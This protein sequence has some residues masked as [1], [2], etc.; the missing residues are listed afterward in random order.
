MTGFSQNNNSMIDKIDVFLVYLSNEGREVYLYD[1]VS[2][3]DVMDALHYEPLEFWKAYGG[4]EIVVNDYY[5]ILHVTDFSYL[6]K[7]TSF[8]IHSLY[9]LS[10]KKAEWFDEDKSGC[11]ILK[12]TSGN[13]V[14]LKK[15]DSDTIC[16]SYLPAEN[17]YVKKRGDK[18][19]EG[20]LFDVVG[21]KEAVNM[22]L[23][24]YFKILNELVLNN[25]EDPMS[26]T[27]K[28]YLKLWEDIKM[29]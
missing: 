18:F 20:V 13:S 2:G 15:R 29:Y 5:I 11:V 4:I 9:W 23:S 19:F 7:V 10:N 1:I 8:L 17:I 27:M 21:W 16:I 3:N 28:K 12:T 24:E 14:S 6:V 25:S 22:A 26:N